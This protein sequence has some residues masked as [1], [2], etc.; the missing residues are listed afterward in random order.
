MILSE[1]NSARNSTGDVADDSTDF[2]Q[3]WIL[4]CEVMSQ[5]MDE[6]IGWVIKCCSDAIHHSEKY[7]PWFSLNPWGKNE[8]NNGDYDGHV[9]S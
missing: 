8:L 9:E 7:R 1:S 2:V 4:E 5:I 6:S 3:S